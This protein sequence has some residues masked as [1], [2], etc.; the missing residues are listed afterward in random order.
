MI[1]PHMENLLGWSTKGKFACPWCNEDTWSLSFQ[2]KKK[3]VI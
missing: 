1:L 2:M 3:I